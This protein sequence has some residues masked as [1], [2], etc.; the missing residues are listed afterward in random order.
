MDEDD[1]PLTKLLETDPKNTALKQLQCAASVFPG[2]YRK[3]GDRLRLEY[4][5]NE[6]YRGLNA[7]FFV[8]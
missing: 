5:D 2:R 8:Q 7:R 1:E 6:N 3:Q 4:T